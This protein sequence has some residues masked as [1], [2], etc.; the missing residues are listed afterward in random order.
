MQ[1]NLDLQLQDLEAN[2]FHQSCEDKALAAVMVLRATYEAI[3][4]T[5]AR[6]HRALNDSLVRAKGLMFF[7]EKRPLPHSVLHE[8]LEIIPVDV[9]L[10][11]D[12][13]QEP[14]L[15]PLLIHLVD[16]IV[17]Q[18]AF[19]DEDVELDELM[20]MIGKARR[21]DVIIQ[22][23]EGLLSQ[24]AQYGEIPARTFAKTLTMACKYEWAPVIDWGIEHDH[25]LSEMSW[26]YELRSSSYMSD[27]IMLFRSGMEW[28]GTCIMR[29]THHSALDDELLIRENLCGISLKARDIRE[30]Q[31]NT[32][33]LVHYL[34]HCKTPETNLRT[35]DDERL[36][37][38]YAPAI[39]SLHL[40]NANVNSSDV[41]RA[42][43][44]IRVDAFRFYTVT[45]ALL[46]RCVDDFD[47][48]TRIIDLHVADRSDVP[49]DFMA[50]VFAKQFEHAANNF[51]SILKVIESAQ[52]HG[53]HLLGDTYK[54]TIVDKF[55][56]F[57]EYGYS[58]E[59]HL[60]IMK[61]VSLF[62]I[63][64]RDRLIEKTESLYAKS[65]TEIQDKFDR[66]APMWLFKAVPAMKRRALS[67]GLGI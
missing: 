43:I 63:L 45:E 17:D 59:T 32:T 36:Q 2:V 1:P 44:S 23:F 14:S 8:L 24:E 57:Q 58:A 41:D 55:N 19:F 30:G 27:G 60:R 39:S 40:L 25:L 61:N 64:P 51:Y 21:F 35:F 52:Q 48:F 67:A 18:Q 50:K 12:W 42:L 38:Y 4:E 15:A 9:T 65:S 66:L 7:H 28:F 13:V 10:L 47:N 5:G 54:N 56:I 29:L 37:E 62:D 33:A 3:R 20:R 49:S 31:L 6:G 53:V 26:N 46:M 34:Y 11:E 22:L 16:Q